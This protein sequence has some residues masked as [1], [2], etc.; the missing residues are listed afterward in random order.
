MPEGHH[1]FKA[2]AMLGGAGRLL[3]HLDHLEPACFGKLEQLGELVGRR[4]IGGADANVDDGP[5]G[6]VPEAFIP[7][8]HASPFRIQLQRHFSY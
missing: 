1:P 6:R 4:L 5:G 3:D 8:L 2:G 7:V